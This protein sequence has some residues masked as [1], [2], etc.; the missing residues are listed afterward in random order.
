MILFSCAFCLFSHSLLQARIIGKR[1]HADYIVIGVGTAGAVLAKKLTDDKKTSVIA[2]HSGENLNNDPLIKFSK[3]VII[4]VPD[5]IIGAPFFQNGNTIRQVHAD[6]RELLWAIALPEG[7]ASAI[8]A[9]A[10]CRGTN[11]VYSQ[12]EAIA[13]PLWS[14]NRILKIYKKLE[15]YHGKTTNP[16]A[17]GFHG[18]IDVRQVPDPSKVSLTFTQAVMNATGFP[19][20]LDYNDPNTPIGV[21]SQFQYT[22]KGRNGRLRVSSATAF[23]NKKVMTP[24]GFGING[25]RLRVLFDSTA[26]RTIWEG[27]KAVGVEYLRHGKV[28]RAFAKKGVIVCCGLKSSFFL[29]HSGVGPRAVLEAFNIPV[30]FDNPNVGQGLADQPGLNVI[31]SSNPADTPL[32]NRNSIFEQISWLPAPGGDPTKREIRIAIVNPIPGIVLTFLDLC[33]A[34]S[35]GSVSIN[36]PD[37]LAPPVIN[38]GELSNPED[39]LLYQQTLQ[40]YVKAINQALQAIDPQYQ[41]IYPNPAILDDPA[42]VTAFIRAGVQSN[43]SFQSHCRMAPLEQGGVVD[44]TGHVYGVQ[45]LLVADDSIVPQPMDG[46]T[47]ATAYL[48]AANI[49]QIL[50]DANQK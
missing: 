15:D 36:S 44:S 11:Q 40:I 4:T 28:K 34:R 32:I 25:R 42:L 1:S 45:N 21:S 2:L 17:R 8:N 49:A 46:S 33:Q 50:I 12:W 5:A 14:V 24:D 3:N 29:L 30:V 31:F 27:N 23:L 48:I 35:R 7:G 39:L 37:P 22:Q 38:L 13:G 20:V 43:Q 26:L 19:F 10:Y 16:G 41:L 6:G 9:G 18:P 47:M